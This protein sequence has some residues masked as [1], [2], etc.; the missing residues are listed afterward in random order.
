MYKIIVSCYYWPAVEGPLRLRA[1][2]IT[3]NRRKPGKRL[4]ASKDVRLSSV[5]TSSL[6]MERRSANRL[7]AGCDAELTTSLS[8]LDT[9]AQLSNESLV[10]LGRTV[11]LSSKGLSLVLPSTPIDQRYCDKE[12]R[13]K[14]SLHLPKGAVSL[15]V[16]PVRCVPLDEEDTALGYLM[17]A[18]ILSSERDKSEYEAFLRSISNLALDK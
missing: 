11:D 8:I 10:F 1:L 7:K 9:D 15:E 6:S 13:I 17:G 2:R 16:S 5:D 18:Q 3:T 4:D 12:A 14:L